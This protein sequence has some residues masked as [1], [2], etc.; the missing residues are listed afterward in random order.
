MGISHLPFC[1]T[2]SKSICS[3]VSYLKKI[4]KGIFWS[5]NKKEQAYLLKW[6]KA[7]RPF[8]EDGLGIV[9]FIQRNRTLLAKSIGR[10]HSKENALL[11]KV[12]AAKHGTYHLKL[13]SKGE[14]SFKKPL[15]IYSSPK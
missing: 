9:D 13:S 2:G 8:M 7:R 11:R 4:L 6:E 3:F 14:V 10:F 5:E 12:I 1:M 15:E